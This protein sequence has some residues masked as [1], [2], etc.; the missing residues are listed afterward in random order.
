MVRTSTFLSAASDRIFRA[1]TTRSF[2]ATPRRSA[3]RAAAAGLHQ[4]VATDLLFLREF[5]HCF[6]RGDIDGFLLYDWLL[7]GNLRIEVTHC[8]I[9]R[10]DVRMGVIKRRLEIAISRSQPLRRRPGPTPVQS[11]ALDRLP[12]RVRLIF[13]YKS[14]L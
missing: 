7:Q 3:A 14:A 4:F 11:P 6:C 5:Q 13:V 9:R 1:A 10:C 12:G 2:R 8:G